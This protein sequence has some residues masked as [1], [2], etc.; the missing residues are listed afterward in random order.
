MPIT[1]MAFFNPSVTMSKGEESVINRSGS[2]PRVSKL[3]DIID[4][5]YCVAT[6]LVQVEEIIGGV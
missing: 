1:F 2:Y 5:I 4:T 6:A 3:L